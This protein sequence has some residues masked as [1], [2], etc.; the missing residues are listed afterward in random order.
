MRSYDERRHNRKVKGLR[1]VR[2]DRAQHGADTSCPCFADEVTRGRGAEFA[3]FADTPK[4]CSDPFC[5]GNT[6]KVYGPT[7]QE[8]RA[9]T[10]ADW[11]E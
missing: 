5:C 8:R 7:R 6:R 4:A 3:R 10:E 9:A 11:D 1:R 2:E